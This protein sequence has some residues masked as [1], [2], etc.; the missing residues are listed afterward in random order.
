MCEPIRILAP[1]ILFHVIN[2]GNARQTVFRDR[3]DFEYYRNLLVR[4][5][6]KYGVHI[7]HYVLMAN[8]IHFLMEPTL[9]NTLSK[10]MQGITISYTKY[11]NKKY[12]SVGHVWQS[13][14]R[15]IPIQSDLYFLRCA[16][17]IELNPVRAQL[18]AHPK[19]YPWSSYHHHAGAVVDPIPDNHSLIDELNG[20]GVASYQN[21]QQFI[22]EDISSAI[23]H[24]SDS[25]SRRP[26][27][28][29]NEFIR[30]LHQN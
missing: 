25:F 7:Y 13:R 22:E 11:F 20:R 3:A 1:H 10:W 30:S 12:Q 9:E 15:S 28:G 14:F 17:Y 6:Q 5:K 8:H 29:S 2:R 23:S 24:T 16:R 18:A 21:F 27:Y 19:D 4:Y 26:I